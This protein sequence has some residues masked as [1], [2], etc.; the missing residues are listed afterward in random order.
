MSSHREAPEIS[1]DP[2]A[3]NT[4]TYAFISPDRPDTVTILTNYIPV[5]AAAG[6]PNFYE[7]GTDVKYD[8]HISNGGKA[9][10]DIVYS[11]AFETEVRDKTTFMYNTG[12][13]KSLDDP[14]FNRRQTYTVTRSIAGGEPA[15]LGK[16]LMCPPCNIGPHSTPNYNG[17]AEE[18]VM[19]LPEGIAVFAGQRNDGFYV[20]LGAVFDMADLR[21]FQTLH[22]APMAP[23]VGVDTFKNSI[24]VH[25]IALQ[26]PIKLLTRN[27]S[28]P[29]DPN[30]P[31]AVIGV[32]GSASRRKMRV[33]GDTTGQHTESG[34]WVQVSRLG[35]PLFNELLVTMTEKGRLERQPAER[36]LRVP[37]R[38]RAPGALAPDPGSLPRAV[39]EP[40]QAQR[41]LARRHDRADP[42]RGEGGHRAGPQHV[43][44]ADP[45]RHAPAEPGGPADVAASGPRC[46]GR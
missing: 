28:V 30:D 21:P 3:D 33:R 25:T 13:I 12:A 34:P 9:E 10:S 19:G 45:V 26:I 27:G 42:H 44:G 29:K 4:D 14:N 38:R 11:F 35:N 36:R 37:R 41:H 5:E 17:L 2:V 43:H 23:S 15:T 18:A 16:G 40:P 22:I 20:D 39:R 6:G 8:I 24:N 32:W 46:A 31:A 7:F 1:Q